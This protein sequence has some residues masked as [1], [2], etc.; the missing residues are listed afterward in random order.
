M[1]FINA[2]TYVSLILNAYITDS[3]N[4]ILTD[5]IVTAQNFEQGILTN[6]SSR[7]L[8]AKLI[9]LNFFILHQL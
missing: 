3:L 5:T 2:H 7:C 1:P 6:F 4:E 9:Q 8:Q